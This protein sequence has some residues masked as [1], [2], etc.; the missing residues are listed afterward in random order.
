M[1]ILA[2]D[3]IDSVGKKLLEDEGITVVTEKVKQ[4]DLIN[5]LKDG[6]FDGIIVRSATKVKS[7]II[8]SCPGIKLI[9]RAGVG[10]DNIDVAKAQEHGMVVLNTPDSSSQSVAELVFAH[11]YSLSRFLQASHADMPQ[12]GTTQFNEL[13]KAY[14]AGIEL[15]GKTLGVIGF[16]RIGQ[17]VAKIGIGSGMKVLAYDPFIKAAELDLDFFGIG[18]IKLEIN[19]CNFN[20]LLLGSDYI[21]LH[22]PHK[23]GATPLIGADQIAKMKKGVVLV[24]AARGGVID[25]AA[26]INAL[27]S[28]Y[29]AGA[30]LDVFLNEPSPAGAL[31]SHPKV[32]ATPHIGASTVEAQERIGVEMAKKIIDFYKQNKRK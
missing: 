3:G 24:N 13:K 26:L 20:D 18:K 27:D 17:A 14:S 22:V 23:E 29:V 30:G 15:K 19:T 32:S 5:Y 16:G 9:G 12:K 31:L 7:D 1:K 11:F 4:E 28:G 21:T 10:L 2:N 25:E 8:Q 6:N